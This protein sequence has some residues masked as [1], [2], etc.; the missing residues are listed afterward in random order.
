MLPREVL[1][2]DNDNKNIFDD[3]EEHVL[4]YSPELRKGKEVNLV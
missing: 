4:W 1:D 2:D 3:K